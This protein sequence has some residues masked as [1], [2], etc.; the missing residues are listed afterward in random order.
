MTRSSK[1][2]RAQTS[3]EYIVLIIIVIG[4]LLA[5]SN[6]FK[7]GLQGRW[8]AAM[9]DMGDQ[10]DPRTADSAVRHTLTQ[11]TNTSIVV[12]NQTTPP[13]SWT[14]RTDESVA[15]ERKQGTV[16]VGAY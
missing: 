12:I 13:G 15:T 8:K 2:I 16:A 10:Y 14:K 11:S 5:M 9:D 7:R 4:A 1:Y 3:L 6:Y